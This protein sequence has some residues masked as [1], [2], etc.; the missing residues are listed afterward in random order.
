MKGFISLIKPIRVAPRLKL[1]SSGTAQ[2]VVLF[3]L[4]SISAL[5][6]Y[7]QGTGLL[8]GRSV[9]HRRAAARDLWRSPGPSKQLSWTTST[10]PAHSSTAQPRSESSRTEVSLS[11]AA[12]QAPYT[13]ILQRFIGNRHQSFHN[14][15]DSENSLKPWHISDMPKQ[16]LQWH[17]GFFSFFLFFSLLVNKKHSLQTAHI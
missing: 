8:Q 5:S 2:S 3:H 13:S 4:V 11:L 12:M 15:G 14:Q 7:R 10:G 6:D 1:N 17:T 16:T 9:S